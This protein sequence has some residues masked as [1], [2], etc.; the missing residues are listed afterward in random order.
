MSALTF[1]DWMLNCGVEILYRDTRRV[2]INASNNTDR[3]AMDEYLLDSSI[4]DLYFPTP[5][6]RVGNCILGEDGEWLSPGGREQLRRRKQI[7]K[8]ILKLKPRLKVMV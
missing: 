8:G 2:L 7:E 4:K 6:Y 1:Q 5:G 3:K